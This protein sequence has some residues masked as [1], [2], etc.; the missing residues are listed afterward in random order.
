MTCSITALFGSHWR[1]LINDGVLLDRSGEALS[2]LLAGP[3]GFP[4]TQELCPNAQNI[5]G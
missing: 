5:A 2:V 3:S 1:G 4:V